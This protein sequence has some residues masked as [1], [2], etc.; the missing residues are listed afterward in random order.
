MTPWP[1]SSPRGHSLEKRLE[2][3]NLQDVAKSVGA[4]FLLIL[5]FVGKSALDQSD[6]IPVGN[7]CSVLQPTYGLKDLD[8]AYD[9]LAKAQ[10]ANDEIGLTELAQR[11]VAILFPAETSCLVI[12]TDFFKHFTFY[13][14]V[15]ILSGPYLERVFWLKVA[16]LQKPLSPRS[17]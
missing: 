2:P 12:E 4:I 11:D 16:S 5:V 8:N 10:K 17:Q 9:E 7:S 1:P 6:A 13:R 14:Q 15:R 3:V